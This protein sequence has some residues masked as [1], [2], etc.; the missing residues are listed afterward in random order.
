MLIFP[1]EQVSTLPPQPGSCLLQPVVLF[2]SRPFQSFPNCL[3]TRGELSPV[4]LPWLY[5]SKRLRERRAV[6]PLYFCVQ[7]VCSRKAGNIVIFTQRALY[8]FCT[9]FCTL[10][11]QLLRLF[12]K[13]IFSSFQSLAVDKRS[14]RLI[15]R[16]RNDGVDR[17]IRIDERDLFNL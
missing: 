8:H 15:G 6:K 1:F 11:A 7:Y 17:S 16:C 2:I 9:I 12:L 3:K 5:I 14:A 4:R 10:R 13:P